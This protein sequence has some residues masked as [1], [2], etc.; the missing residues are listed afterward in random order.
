V[1]GLESLLTDTAQTMLNAKDT[2]YPQTVNRAVSPQATTEKHFGQ[3]VV[4]LP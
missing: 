3:G 4:E 2:S 1:S